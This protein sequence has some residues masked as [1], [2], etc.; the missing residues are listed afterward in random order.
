ME[1]KS[2]VPPQISNILLPDIC[3]VF[4]E[5]HSHQND[6][7]LAKPRRDDEDAGNYD[8]SVNQLVRSWNED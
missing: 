6:G 3:E 4:G 7:E 5:D 8:E 2:Y 1:K